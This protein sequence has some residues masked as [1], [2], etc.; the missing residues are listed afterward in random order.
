M[1]GEAIGESGIGKE[2]AVRLLLERREAHV[3]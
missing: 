1:R 3:Y 2:N